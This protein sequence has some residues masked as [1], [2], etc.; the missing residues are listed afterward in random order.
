VFMSMYVCMYVC[1]Y[2][3]TPDVSSGSNGGQRNSSGG[4]R[5]HMSECESKSRV[6]QI[7]AARET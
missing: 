7:C 6:L 1:V 2:I 5:N 3:H 4:V